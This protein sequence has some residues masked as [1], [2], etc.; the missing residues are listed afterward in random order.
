MSTYRT[1][2]RIEKV[3]KSTEEV[4]ETS[5]NFPTHA[6]ATQAMWQWNREDWDRY[7]EITPR[8]RKQ[9]VAVVLPA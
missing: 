3:L 2:Y 5:R 9:I 7:G 4:L 8:D 6:A 1:E